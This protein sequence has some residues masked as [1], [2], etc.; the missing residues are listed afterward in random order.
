M[1][2]R[3]ALLTVDLIGGACAAPGNSRRLLITLKVVDNCNPR[4]NAVSDTG[5]S[6]PH[7]C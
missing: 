6:T 5:A 2:E 7:H 4:T 1:M 3:A